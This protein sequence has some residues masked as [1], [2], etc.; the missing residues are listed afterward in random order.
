M[1]ADDAS[2]SQGR[3]HPLIYLSADP[4][5][6][7]EIESFG[8]GV[9]A[10]FWYWR[11]RGDLLRAI[12]A[13]VLIDSGAFSAMTLGKRVRLADY[14]RFLRLHGEGRDYANLDV[15]GDPVLT[16]RNQSVL[17][18]E[19]LRPIPVFHYGSDWRWLDEIV[20]RH[21]R[22]AIG[23]IAKR[24][25]SERAAVDAWVAEVFRR[26]GGRRVHGFGCT[27]ER[28][29]R[30]HP[31]DS[32]DSVSWKFGWSHADLWLYD[33]R[34][35]RQVRIYDRRSVAANM[36]LLRSYGIEVRRALTKVDRFDLC[37]AGIES[38]RR[39]SE[40]LS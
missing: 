9:L 35:F 3:R 40:A 24:I 8:L 37:R 14:A 11:D 1:V 2:A 39:F 32:A 16:A 31:F 15:I 12:E 6:A 27:A 36:P 21:D 26:I 18:A 5:S 13:P 33:G 30:R 19:G 25:F 10:S 22:L 28:L 38:M 7:R 20:E 17:E 34:R 23:G 4:E 29:L